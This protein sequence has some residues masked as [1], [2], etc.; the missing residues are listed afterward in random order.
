VGGG[1]EQCI[2]LLIRNL[3]ARRDECST[4]LP[5][6]L[7]SRKNIRYQSYRKLGG[8]RGRSKLLRKISPPSPTSVIPARSESLYQLSYPGHHQHQK[9]RTNRLVSHYATPF[10]YSYKS[11][12]KVKFTVQQ[13]TKTQRRSRCIAILFL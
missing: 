3:D 8:R 9:T 7:A 5:G 4:S 2:D 12:V 6:R 13:A 10:N 1:G 11:H